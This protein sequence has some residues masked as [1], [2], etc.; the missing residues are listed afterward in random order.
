LMAHRP[1]VVL[2]PCVTRGICFC[3]I[4]PI[5]AIAGKGVAQIQQFLDPTKN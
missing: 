4:H 3:N 1:T 2:P 5:I